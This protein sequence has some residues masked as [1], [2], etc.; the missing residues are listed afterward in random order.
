MSKCLHTFT[1][2]S[3]LKYVFLI[4]YN[5]LGLDVCGDRMSLTLLS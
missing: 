4:L 1:V 5:F 3:L 2:L